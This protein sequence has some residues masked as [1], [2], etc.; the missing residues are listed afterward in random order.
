MSLVSIIV[1]CFNQAQ[2]LS[3]AL[4][5]V[6]MQTYTNW[7]CIIVND[8]SPDN[9]EEVAKKW[10]EID[11]RFKYIYQDNQGLSA[12]RNSGIS[13]AIGNYIL[14]LDADD[15][16]SKLY[17]TLAVDAFKKDASL[18]I[19]YCRAEKFGEQ[20]GPLELQP[21][22]PKELCR[23]NMIFCSALYKK[24]DWEKVGGYDS[25]MLFG[26]ED[27]EFWISILKN[28]GKVFVLPEIGF[29]YRIKKNSMLKKINPEQEKILF[30]YMSVKHVKFFVEHLGS[31]IFLNKTILKI[32]NENAMNLGSEKFLIN[33]ICKRF[34][35]FIV[36]RMK[37][38]F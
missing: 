4:E 1:P 28:G 12:A 11:N 34:F 19:V 27:W 20:E 5:S 21:F 29:F 30:E 9:T 37:K 16:I 22:S 3:E 2:F 26:L 33:A 18:T 35:G 25:N 7:E 38:E 8:G 32:K 17:T 15:K 24:S 36:F 13:Q 6:L 14:P 23:D 31:F 10:L